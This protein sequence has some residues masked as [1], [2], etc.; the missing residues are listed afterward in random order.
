MK[1]LTRKSP[2]AWK[3]SSNTSNYPRV[4]AEITNEIRKYFELHGNK[5]MISKLANIAKV[6]LK[7]NSITLNVYTR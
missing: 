5:N 1:I 3:L 6:V 4:K 7:G 2:N